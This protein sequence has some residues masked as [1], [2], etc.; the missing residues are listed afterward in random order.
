MDST[1]KDNMFQILGADDRKHSSQNLCLGMVGDL[2]LM[3]EAGGWAGS[4]SVEML[5]RTGSQNS[6]II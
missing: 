2:N 6:R 3:N 5:G 4:G 1:L